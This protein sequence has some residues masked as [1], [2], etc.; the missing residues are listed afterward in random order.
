MKRTFITGLVTILLGLLIALGPQTLFKV[1]GHDEGSFPLCHWSARAEIGAGLLISAL[2]IC[3]IGF[4]DLGTQLGLTIGIFFA[5]IV[6]LFIPH[7]LIG[8]CGDMAMA[9]RRVAFPVLSII[10]AVTIIGSFINLIFIEV[11]TKNR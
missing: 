8:G 2:G 11:M 7:V 4:S 10:C 6:A 3:L 5:S 1:C 9:C